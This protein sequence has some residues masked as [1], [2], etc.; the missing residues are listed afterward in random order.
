M[1]SNAEA[2]VID[3]PFNRG[4]RQDLESRIAPLGALT[5]CVNLEF[6]QLNRLVRREGYVTIGTFNLGKVNPLNFPVRRFAEM[7]SGEQCIFTDQNTHLYVPNADRCVEAGLS[8]QKSS[9]KATLQD[10]RGIAASEAGA[11]SYSDSACAPDGYAVYA[12]VAANATTGSISLFIDVVD[13]RTDARIIT[14]LELD[15]NVGLAQ[16][17]VVISGGTS[18]AFVIWVATPSTTIKYS[19]I[20]LGAQPIVPA[21]AASLVTD[22]DN[23]RVFDAAPMFG[24]NWVFVYGQNNAGL[25]SRI[26]TLN[27]AGVQVNTFAWQ[28]AAGAAW[29]PSA[30]GIDGGANSAAHLVRAVGYDGATFLIESITLTTALA[31]AQQARFNPG[32]D[33]ARPVRQIAIASTDPNTAGG[34][35]TFS[36]CT[37]SPLTSNPRGHSHVYTQANTAVS[38]LVGVFGNY[39]V[40]SKFFYD[41]RNGGIL[42]CLRFDDPSGFQNH[43]LLCDYGNS[44]TGGGYGYPVP[45]LHFASGRMQLIADNAAA[46]SQPSLSKL[47]AA[48]QFQLVGVFNIGSSQIS[49]NQAI[50]YTFENLGHDRYLNTT[51]Q[52]EVFAAGGTPL[53]YD[54]QRLVENSFYSYPCVGSGSF[55]PSAAGGFMAQGVYQYKLVYE[56]TDAHGNRHQSPASPAVTVDMSSATYVAGTNS[57]SITV[58]CLHAT[59]KQVQF[60]TGGGAAD[61]AFPVCVIIYRTIPSTGGS[62]F[63]RHPIPV[64]NNAASA[65]DD[66]VVVDRLADASISANEVLYTSPGGQGKLFSTAPPASIFVSTHQQRLCGIDCEN[67]ERI[68]FTKFF[69]T[70]EQPGYNPGLQVIIPGAGSIKGLGSQDGKLYALATNGIY[71]ASYG[72]GPDNTGAGAFPTPQL[73]TTSANCVTSRGVLVGQDGIYFVGTDRW[74]TGIYLIPRGDGTPKS[75]G[76]RVRNLLATTP[77]CV[78]VIDRIN[79]DRTEFAFVDSLTTP[80]AGNIL[81]YHHSYLDDEGIGQWTSV[82]VAGS[83]DFEAFGEW[84]DITVVANSTIAGRQLTTAADAI[85]PDFGSALPAVRITTC[86]M[87]PFGLVGYGQVTG[88]TL[89]GTDVSP[90]VIKAEAS[91]NSGAS[92]TDAKQFATAGE[93]EGDPLLRGWQMPTSKLPNGGCVRFRFSDISTLGTTYWHGFSLEAKQLGGNARLPDTKRG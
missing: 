76:L 12:Y 42:G 14:Q 34:I 93:A 52:G 13:T 29:T 80:T 41:S 89:L 18:I 25:R 85:N 32:L 38:T 21:G 70:L 43:M 39:S 84:A 92:Y 71:L 83:S 50:A 48:G 88:L 15:T 23:T 49:G 56:W 27:S 35:Y 26:M 57:V 59:R 81:Y 55:V 5:E 30:L 64:V 61:N 54:G 82:A 79:K 31:G 73:I 4:L 28:A 11:I 19:R 2:S 62:V 7:P 22:A 63:Y 10:V 51:A 40:G 58:P 47:V 65:A 86:D 20:D 60:P 67:T 74:G 91:Y 53:A 90:D 33:H 46:L 77:Y 37:S 6:D 36:N 68:W 69:E 66:A 8:G 1:S 45:Q 24:S 17:R 78:G 9:L 3:V 87:R 16:P 72:D 75:I 44:L